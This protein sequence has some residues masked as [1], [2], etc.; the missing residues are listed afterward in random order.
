VAGAEPGDTL[1]L[2]LMALEPARDWGASAAIPFFGGMTSTDR[3]VTL[4]EP[5]PDATW[6]YE[7]DR[8]RNTVAV[9]ARHSDHRIELP[10]E[11][12]LGTVGVPPVAT[13]SAPL[14]CPTVSAATRTPPRCGPG[15]RCSSV[16][17]EGA[18]FSIGDGHYRQGD[19]E[20]CG[21]AVEGAMAS[22]LRVDSIEGG[23]PPRPRSTNTH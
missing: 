20:A 7:L 22:T 16:N 13:R 1:V 14:W 18:M 12:M 5:L 17:V 6:I 2:H 21:T 15:R 9:A 3:V 19:G 8:V 23:A 11:P 4:Q 10:V